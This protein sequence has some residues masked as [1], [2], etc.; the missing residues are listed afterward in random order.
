MASR[1]QI[2]KLRKLASD[3]EKEEATSAVHGA[4]DR[5]VSLM[6]ETP[7][8]MFAIHDVKED[9]ELEQAAASLVAQVEAEAKHSQLEEEEYAT[10]VLSQPRYSCT[11]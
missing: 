1:K 5:C 8:D 10:E 2:R 11:P 7:R 6:K 3:K 9:D 4:V